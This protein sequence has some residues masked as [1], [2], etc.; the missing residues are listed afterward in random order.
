MSATV[1]RLEPKRQ[2]KNTDVKKVPKNLQYQPVGEHLALPGRLDWVPVNSIV[3]D[4]TYQRTLSA[5]QVT[6]IARAFDPFI[7]GVIIVSQRDDGVLYVL[8]GQHRVE[9]LRH[10]GYEN[11]HIPAMVYVNLT[12]EDEARIFAQTN[13]NRMYLPPQ[14]HFRARLVAG[15]AEAIQI[16]ETVQNF[17]FHLNYWKPL[18]GEDRGSATA[19]YKP[20]GMLSAIGELERL[21]RS[22]IERLETVLGIARDA[23]GSDVTG[24]SAIVLRGIAIFHRAFVDR[25]DRERLLEVMRQTSLTR[26]TNDGRDRGKRL[27]GR[28]PAGVCEELWERYNFHLGAGRRLPARNFKTAEA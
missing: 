23:W 22:G 4:P 26:L 16:N 27:G 6:T 8:D 12:L 25:Y 5:K 1:T 20:E 14:Y 18:P 19:M 10:L 11:D 15:D 3:A 28:T 13:K 9:A 24:L 21:T 7:L 17:G 2:S